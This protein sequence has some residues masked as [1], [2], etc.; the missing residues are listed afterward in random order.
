MAAQKYAEAERIFQKA[1]DLDPESLRGV[2]VDINRYLWASYQAQ[3]KHDQAK[4]LNARIVSRE[5]N[6]T[7]LTRENF[8]KL[9]ITLEKKKIQLFVM[10]YPMR[11]IAPLKELLPS[12]GDIV[13]LENKRNFMEA[14][15]QTKY[16]DYLT[17][18]FAGDFGH[19]TPKGNALLAQHAADVILKN[20]K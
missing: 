17:D 2:N 4:K 19:C 12:V 3:G 8:Q 7:P 5:G 6:Y 13:F 1:L 18:R 9:K 16:D 15:S 10:Q 14:V 11:D 20:L